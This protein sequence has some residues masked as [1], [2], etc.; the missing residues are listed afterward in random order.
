MS[1]ITYKG[2]SQN[3]SIE[4]KL[5]DEEFKNIAIEFYKK[6]DFKK[7]L[8]QFVS[9]HSGSCKMDK[10]YQYYLKQVMSK[11]IGPGASWSIDDGLHY[12]PIMEYF[13][14]KVDAGGDFFPKT[15]TLAENIE[16]A[17]RLCGIRYCVKLPNYPIQSVDY[18]LSKYNI[19]NNWYDYSC[20]WAARMLGALKNGVNYF[21]T[22]PNNELF[23][24][25]NQIT[26]DYKTVN[27]SSISKVDIR[28]TGSEYYISEWEHK[29]GV[30]FSSPPYYNMEDYV[31]GD[32]SYKAGVTYEEWLENYM[33]KT[34]KNIYKYLI[35]EGYFIINIK[36]FKEYNLEDDTNRIATEEG[37]KLYEIESLKNIKRCHGDAKSKRGEKTVTFN[38]NDEHIYVFKKKEFF[39]TIPE[40]YTQ[41][42][43]LF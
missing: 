31:I 24:V 30:C 42:S 2:I 11:A 6:P 39:D 26:D 9:I 7:V 23:D 3:S 4:R 16:T 32:Q 35:D 28:N 20:G 12:K 8:Q 25:L 1:L 37:F 21:G 19:N 27:K 33:R 14:G 34:I 38:D 40:I 41:T 36:N 15:F 18:I 17:F 29:M 13:A 43:K 10:I 5:T 22:D